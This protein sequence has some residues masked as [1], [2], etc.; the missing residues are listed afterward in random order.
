[1]K[2][3]VALNQAGAHQ[4]AQCPADLVLDTIVGRYL[5]RARAARDDPPAMDALDG[6]AIGGLLYETFGQEM[7]T[8][9]GTCANCGARGPAAELRVYLRAPGAVG[10]CRSCG[11][12][13]IVM[14]QVRGTTC[15]DLSGYAALEPAA[16]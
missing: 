16:A 3:R 5:A 4:A 6:N 15:V 14:T 12:I 8:A 13:L 1:M 10:R 9:V 11:A 2:V 7:T